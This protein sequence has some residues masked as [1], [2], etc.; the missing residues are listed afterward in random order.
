MYSNSHFQFSIQHIKKEDA[1]AVEKCNSTS[2]GTVDVQAKKFFYN[3][4]Q[5]TENFLE[6]RNSEYS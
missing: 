5:F 4:I 2:N 1:T 3:G 6:V